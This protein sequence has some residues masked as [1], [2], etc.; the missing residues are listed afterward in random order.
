MPFCKQCGKENAPGAQFC[1]E[2][3]AVMG[4]GA[5]PAGLPQ[6]R[7]P[8]GLSGVPDPTKRLV[9]RIAVALLILIVGWKIY[10][11]FGPSE[12]MRRAEDLM[13]SGMYSQAQG[14]FGQ[15]LMRSPKNAEAHFL[16]AVC[17]IKADPLDSGTAKSHFASAMMLDNKYG[18]RIRKECL[19]AGKGALVG[20]DDLSEAMQIFDFA[21]GQADPAYLREAA[22]AILEQGKAKA[23]ATS[24]PGEAS[25]YFNAA[26]TLNP[27]MKD[28]IADYVWQNHVSPLDTAGQTREALSWAEVCRD[29][30]PERYKEQYDLLR[31][32][33]YE[34][35][36]NP[37]GSQSNPWE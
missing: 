35:P 4:E 30:A 16:M 19:E 27:A 34:R 12:T 31:S 29:L 14:M 26:A 28:E 3:G 18:S 20:R 36:P 25:S 23:M 15:E 8:V 32:K 9:I 37:W 24:D 7:T 5:P 10:R 11:A 13:K 2:C 22:S 6:V 21:K 33:A 1:G 17:A